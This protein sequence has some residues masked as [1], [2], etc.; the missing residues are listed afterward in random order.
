MP[1]ATIFGVLFAQ[2]GAQLKARAE[3]IA[4]PG[5]NSSGAPAHATGKGGLHIPPGRPVNFTHVM[6][7]GGG[8]RWDIQAYGNIGSGTNNCYGNGMYLYVNNSNFHS[9]NRGWMNKDGDEIE[10]GPCAR[11]NIR[12]YRR[13]K[14]YAKQPLARFLDI[15]ENP[16]SQNVSVQVRVYSST[17][18]SITRTATSSGGA[19]FDAEKDIGFITATNGNNVPSLLHVLSDKRAKMKPAT[20]QVQ[21]S[22]INFYYNLAI[23][24]GKTVV[25]CHFESQNRSFD[26]QEKLLKGF[27]AYR[28]LRDLSPGVRKLIV[29][30]RASGGYGDID[31]QRSETAD[32]VYLAAGEPIFGTIVNESFE[33]DAAFGRVKMDA[34]DVIGMVA[35][36]GGGV[37]AV[38]KDGQIVSGKA[39]DGKLRIE[40]TGMKLA[41]PFT[42]MSRWSY[43]I[44]PERSDEGVFRGPF[45]VL[46]TG[47]RLAFEADS[48]KLSLRTRHGLIPLDVR[49]LMGV[50]L[51]NVSNAVHQARFVNGSHVAGLLEPQQITAKL[52]LG[53]ELSVAR[54]MVASIQATT[55]ET[56]NPLLTHVL[57]SNG[58]ELF[59]RIL[60]EQI[61]L[62]TDYG[63]A[64]I[65]P[66][67]LRE[68]R[69]SATHLGRAALTLWDNSILRGRLDLA[70]VHFQIVPGPAITLNPSQIVHVFRRAA[71]PPEEVIARID[72]LVALL[73][74]ESHK[75]RQQAT[76]ELK[77]MG[78]GI[79]PIL[80]R[81]VDTTDPEVLRR[82]RDVIDSLG[83][84]EGVSN[85]PAE[86][87][88]GTQ[89]V[90][91]ILR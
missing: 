59:G 10:T 54:D 61:K 27:R 14:V 68:L 36:R 58:D 9:N 20:V 32:A 70:E 49:R 22:Q 81:H 15:F 41:I 91:R 57:L 67:N 7:D 85:A 75:D 29:N 51:D 2:A 66:S 46:R 71:L 64:N 24:A 26:A 28:Y 88:A 63:Q 33:I 73:G 65:K 87:T 82:L 83:G 35:E 16:T 60:D 31:L 8:Y 78:A 72:K 76:E 42:D 44:S 17:N 13:V 5:G 86:P 53:G 21:G 84:D 3:L 90:F 11:N 56:P 50:S 55:E 43:R 69:F 77:G 47:D 38:L 74:S 89:P 12:V 45:I 52:R 1:L 19:A 40:K 62:Q 37:L 6:T 48:L 4:V 30:L 80:R 25:L 23:P 39:P 18:Y 34:A 79:V